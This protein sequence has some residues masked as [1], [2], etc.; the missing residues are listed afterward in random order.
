MRVVHLDCGE[1]WRGGQQQVYLLHRELLRSGVHSLVLAPDGSALLQ[2][3]RSEGLA[4]D[5]LPGRRPWHA[6][7]GALTRQL[8]SCELVH[9]HDSHAAGLAA[10]ASRRGARPEWVCHR[11][12]SYRRR[13]LPFAKFKYGRVAAWIAVSTEVAEVLERS[14]V[15]QERCAVIHSAVD[16]PAL[17]AAAAEVDS[18]VLAASLGLE[19]DEPVVGTVG[20][21]TAQKGQSVLIEAVAGILESFPKARFLVVG[22][23]PLR[24]RLESEAGDYG[25]RVLFVGHRADVPALMRLFTVFV[26]TSIDGEGSPAV[27]KEAMALGRP[28][29]ASDLP[30][31]KEIVGEAG[32]LVNR[33]D[34]QALVES[35]CALLGDPDS[36]HR[37]VER[38][39]AAAER[40]RVAT[41][42]EAT[43]AVYHKVLGRAST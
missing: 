36:R 42:A 27:V 21:L 41:M 32:V 9:S 11:R 38:A 25:D 1:S 12:V 6:L 15:R 17:R 19:I 29:V 14:G 4:C 10:V 23:G 35:V 13:L 34:P 26:S 5:S 28:V 16:L 24:R 20:A 22:D 33:A 39:E 40:F 37:L 8:R 43:L 31:H 7:N 18:G 30:G 2:R 3:L